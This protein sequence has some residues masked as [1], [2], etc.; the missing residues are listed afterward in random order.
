M[1]GLDIINNRFIRKFRASLSTTLRKVVEIDVISNIHLSFAKV[2]ASIPVPS[3]INLLQFDPLPGC[4]FIA[5]DTNLSMA[6]LDYL[7]G[8]KGQ[9][10]KDVKKEE[11]APIEQHLMA[12]IAKQTIECLEDIWKIIFPI[13]I[14]A[15]DM[16]FDSRYITTVSHDEMFVVTHFSIKIEG[17]DGSL[18]LALP[19]TTLEPIK[20]K[21]TSSV[22]SHDEQKVNYSCMNNLK[23][24]VKQID[25]NITVEIGQK[26]VTVHD[27][28]KMKVGD[29][30]IL[31]Q[32]IGNE[33]DVYVEKTPKF[34]GYAGHYKGNNALKITSIPFSSIKGEKKNA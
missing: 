19:Y 25:A 10:P 12:K 17:A 4:P 30:I 34:K 1:V 9:S 5:F 31:N 21:L 16:E 13:K 26:T 6:L 32:F 28:V 33:L 15:G 24:F 23:E 20:Q 22:I 11:F 27:L 8:G 14:Y 3:C 7:C 2:S 18:T 29:I